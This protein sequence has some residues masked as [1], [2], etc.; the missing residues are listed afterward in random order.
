MKLS[1]FGQQFAAESGTYSLMRD[2]GD[3]I[4]ENPDLI[5]MGG[6]NPA[7]I[8]EVQAEF[9]RELQAIMDDPRSLG[10]LLGDYQSPQGDK[11]FLEAVANYVNRRFGWGIGSEHVAI[12]NGSQSAFFVLFNLLAGPM[13][14]GGV[15]S[16]ALPM[17]P[18]YAGYS[19]SI[20]G[21][22]Y[23]KTCKPMIEKLPQGEF[24]YH[25]DFSALKGLLN[26]Q[27]DQD[28]VGAM[29]V[30]R[31]GNP[32]GNVLTDFEMSELS[33]LAKAH[34][35]PLIV[36]GAYGLPFP[37]IVFNDAKA[38]W[39]ENTI[40][41]LTLSKLG[42]P[43]TRTGVVIARPDIIKAFTQANTVLSLSAGSIGP[44]LTTRWLESGHIDTICQTMIQPFYRQAAERTA[45]QLREGLVDLPVHIHKPEGAMF[46]WLWCEGLPIASQALYER[47]KEK[48]VLVVSG[49]KFFV[50][51][52]DDWP[53]KHECLRV[54]YC[55][56]PEIMKQGVDIIV[57]EIRA[58]YQ[59]AG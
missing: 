11:R 7:H 54:S 53:H 43:G 16:I 17:S 1:Q 8:P 19:G 37:S 39:N 5:F 15:S 31:P 12:S 55:Q 40:L 59:Q 48:G 30:S 28:R 29:C 14:N 3:A 41:L 33:E 52:Q 36:D 51:V 44:M 25:I 35:V 6:G 56:A 26:G 34:D 57:D 20:I 50:G 4:N 21:G 18:E 32:T 45:Q 58:V 9:K 2:L 24:K 47:L 23:F 38:D 13:S 49:D 42:L 10:K 27:T 22:E 46:L